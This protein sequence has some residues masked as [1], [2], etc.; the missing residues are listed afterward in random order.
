MAQPSTGRPHMPGYGISEDLEGAL[1]WSWAEDRL[2]S[3]RNYWISTVRPDGRPHAMPVWALWHQGVL[4]FSTSRTSTK[5]RNLLA[6]P[7]CTV[8]SESG[9][10]AL[11]VE[12]LASVIADPA[13]LQPIWD[14]YKAKYDWDVQGEPMFAVTPSVAFAFLET[15]AAFGTA[16]T[17]W[18]FG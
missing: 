16:A 4:Y 14:A 13:V 1:P 2:A 6:N 15:A 12:G 18:T 10:E 11:I 3:G 17:R 8:T 7:N 5:A 9:D